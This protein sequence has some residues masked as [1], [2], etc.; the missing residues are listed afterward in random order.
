MLVP[1]GFT[2]MEMKDKG[3][4]Y[5]LLPSLRRLSPGDLTAQT[6]LVCCGYDK[7]EKPL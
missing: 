4:G 5:N 7:T 3:F 1:C 2:L 6:S